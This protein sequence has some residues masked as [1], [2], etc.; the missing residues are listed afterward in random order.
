MSTNFKALVLKS[1]DG[2]VFPSIDQLTLEALPEGDVVIDVRY[3]SINYKDAMAIGNRGIIR[4]FPAIPGIDFAGTVRTSANPAF[5]P[6]DAVV[7]TGWGVGERHW[8]GYSQVA[9]VKSEWLV[10]LPAGLDLKQSMQIGTAGLTAMLCVQ[11][12]EHQGVRPD[13]GPVLVTGASGGVGSVAVAVLAKLGYEVWAMTRPDQGDYL[14]SLGAK[15]IVGRNDFAPSKPGRPILEAETF[16]GVV[17][18]VGGQT[19]A[20]LIARVAYRGSIASCGL[21]GGTDVDTTV[22]PFILRGVNLLGVD[23]VRCPTPV[24]LQAW[25]RLAQDLPLAMLDHASREIALEQVPE[26]AA[27]LLEGRG[28]GRVVVDLQR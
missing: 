13:A 1:E 10:P 28:H 7:L 16:A 26:I 15:K 8:G 14:A 3:S 22:Y 25:Q 17:D 12:L 2:K 19:L 21:V 23:S 4:K 24:R 6:G 9:R 27:E 11:A 5:K 20:A 18:T